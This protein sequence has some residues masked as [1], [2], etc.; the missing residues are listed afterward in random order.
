MIFSSISDS[1]MMLVLFCI[2]CFGMHYFEIGDLE[3]LWYS[4]I[5]CNLEHNIHFRT[6]N[7]K[8]DGCSGNAWKAQILEGKGEQGRWVKLEE[9]KDEGFLGIARIGREEEVLG[10]RG[11]FIC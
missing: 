8:L 6:F 3:M 2:K 11:I 5:L 7:L 10:L 1:R 4:S 9:E